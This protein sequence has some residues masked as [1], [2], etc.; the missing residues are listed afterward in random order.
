MKLN[1]LFIAMLLVMLFAGSRAFACDCMRTRPS[2]QEYWEAA[3]VFSG[4]VIDIRRVTVKEGDYEHPMRAVRLSIDQAFRGVEGA[5]VEV[6]TGFGGGDCG[7]G[8][9][10]TEQYLVYAYRS[11]Q[12]QKLHTSICTRTRLLADAKDD[13]AYIR[14]LAKAK[15]GG[16]ISGEVIRHLRDA[17]GTMTNQPLSGIKVTFAGPDKYEAVTDAKGEFRI[18]AVTPG[19]YTVKPSAPSGLGLRGPD[20]KATVADKGCAEVE[21]WL[22]SNAQLSGRVLNPQ[23]LPVAKAEIFMLDADK[24][25]YGGHWDAAYADDEGKYSFKFIP[26]GRY[27]LQIRFD[28]LTS[29]T[30]PF[31]EMY[32]PGIADRSQ[33]KIITVRTGEVI[34]NYDIQV[35]PLPPEAE[36]RGM[37]TWSDGR[38]APAAHVEIEIGAIA[39]GA[40]L[41]N[42]GRFSYTAYQ[43]LTLAVRASVEIEKGKYV[44]SDWVRVTAGVND[45]SIK[46]VLPVGK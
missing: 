6:L 42:Q 9:R 43:G 12:D 22:E 39:Y 26:S 35:P 30:R 3:A 14:G 36:I 1:Q 10:Q 17:N 11:E 32:Y 38:L 7:F 29:Q 33:A 16:T 2:C 4:T 28:G 27:I 46:L 15:P 24:E 41:D 18:E 8:F 5:E 13:L 20:R 23:G 34:E 40:P 21:F 25:K 45:Q 19:E 37:V 31:P 44:Y